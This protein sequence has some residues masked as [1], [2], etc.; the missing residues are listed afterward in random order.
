MGKILTAILGLVGI[1][2][3]FYMF[4]SMMDSLKEMRTDVYGE[5]FTGVTTAPG[6]TNASVS[7]T[8]ALWR[9]KTVEV[10]S[11]TST[12]GGDTPTPEGYVAAGQLLYVKGLA[13]SST[14]NLT[15]QY[16][17][18]SLSEYS[19]LSE[20]SGISPLLIFLGFIG[21]IFAIIWGAFKSR[22]GG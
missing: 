2:L 7:L 4:P 16:N 11:I 6:I 12:N 3:L 9:S 19:G 17:V 21:I 14:R 1:I 13:A 10:N 22:S 5:N 18:N 8:E 15:V 20:L